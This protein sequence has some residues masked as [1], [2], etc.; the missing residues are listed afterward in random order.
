MSEKIELETEYQIFLKEQIEHNKQMFEGYKLI[1]EITN[2][3][4]DLKEYILNDKIKKLK[5]EIKT[6]KNQ[7]NGTKINITRSI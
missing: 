3:N 6:L 5:E 4:A 2:K 7:G 1:F